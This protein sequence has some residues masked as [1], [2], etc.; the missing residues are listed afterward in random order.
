MEVYA[1]LLCSKID[2]QLLFFAWASW[3]L[4]LNMEENKV[5]NFTAVEWLIEY[6]NELRNILGASK[7][8]TAL[9]VS[10][11]IEFIGKF[12]STDSL[13]SGSNCGA[14]FESALNEF[15]SLK[16]YSGKNLYKLL[17]CGLAHRAGLGEGILLSESDKTS[18]D[19]TPMTLNVPQFY[20]DFSEAVDLAR[21]RKKWPNTEVLSPYL[22]VT[23]QNTTGA[24]A[25]T[26]NQTK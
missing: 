10:S 22:T 25:T 2:Y 9:G 11:G 12:L 3:S 24:T 7:F 4:D 23:E 16:K 14:K 19:T 13:D 15:D 6:R 26:K 21:K 8:I 20:E 18:L 1:F 5:K 17:R